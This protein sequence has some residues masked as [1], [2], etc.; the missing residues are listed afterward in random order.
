LSSVR[1]GRLERVPALVSATPATPV[2][3]EPRQRVEDRVE[4]RRDV[5]SE[6][7]D[8][9]A[10]IADHCRRSGSCDVLDA[11]DEACA[12][13][14]SRENDDVQTRLPSSCA[15]HACVRGPARNWSRVRSSIVST[16]SAR[17]GSAIDTASTPSEAAC[18][19]K[20][21]ALLGPYSGANASAEGRLRAFVVPSSASTRPRQPAGVAASS[22]R[23]SCGTTHGTSALTTWF[24][25]GATSYR[26][27]CKGKPLQPPGRG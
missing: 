24:S 11:D 7:L 2:V 25:T 1:A 19:L 8:V 21:S 14:A 26:A 15:R 23:R 10:D 9:V 12:A 6:H 4:V 17:F 16:S 27:A 5:K 20:R 18:A 3:R 13:H 22:E